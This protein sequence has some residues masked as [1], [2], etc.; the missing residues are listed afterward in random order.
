MNYTKGEWKAVEHGQ[1]LKIKANGKDIATVA[2]TESEAEDKADAQLIESAPDL[3]EAL[4]GLMEALEKCGSEHSDVR[5]A[6]N[7]AKPAL[8]KVEGK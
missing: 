5:V 4:K 3:Y 1:Q 2:F 7:L 6:Y 8:A